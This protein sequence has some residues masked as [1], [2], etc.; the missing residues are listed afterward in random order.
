M[1][2]I[3]PFPAKEV[4][5]TADQDPFFTHLTP[6]VAASGQGVRGLRQPTHGRPRRRSDAAFPPAEIAA[7]TDADGAGSVEFEVRSDVENESLG[8]Q[9]QGRLLDRR[10]PDQRPVL[11]PAVRARDDRR[12]GLPQGRALPAGLE[13]LRQ[14]GRRPGGVAGAV[15]VGVQ[16]GATGSRSRSPSACR[17]T[18][19]TSSTRARRPAS[20][21]PSCWP[22]PSLQ[23]SPAYCLDKKRFKFQLN[24]MSDEA[25]WNLMESGGG[26]AAVRL[27]ASTSAEARTRSAYAPTAVTGFSIGYVIDRPDNAGEYTDLRLNA[28]L[29]AKLMTQSYLG[30]DLGRGHPGIGDN[31]LGIMSRPRVH[32]SS[33]RASARTPRR[34]ARRCCRCPTPAT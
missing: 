26:A 18:P 31:P 16:L 20:T 11:R 23:W 25:G 4:C 24:Q 6:F 21:A 1:S 14:R 28:R 2:G 32:R 33:T 9:P 15:V 7:F 3:D 17:R 27:L 19:A 13:Q 34:P 5:P 10:H 22:R 8:L 30:S 12:R 29:I